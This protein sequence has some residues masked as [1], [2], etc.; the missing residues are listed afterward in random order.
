M[1]DNDRIQW[2]AW[3][4]GGPDEPRRK[5]TWRGWFYLLVM[6]ITAIPSSIYG[7]AVVQLEKETRHVG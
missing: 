5:S 1:N 7:W 4:H 6:G 2:L 3:R